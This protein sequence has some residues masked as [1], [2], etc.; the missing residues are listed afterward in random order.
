MNSITSSIGI[1]ILLFIV[2]IFEGLGL[3]FGR[4][5]SLC[6]ILIAPSILF[7]IDIYKRKKIQIP[8]HI[9]IGFIFFSI[10]A[11]I[12]TFT[13]VHIQTAF[14]HQLYYFTIFL[15]FL[16]TYN[17][18]ENIK[19]LLPQFIVTSTILVCLFTVFINFLLPETWSWLIPRNGYQFITNTH[20]S[21]YPIG[22]FILIPLI[23]CTS[24]LFKK[25]T[26]QTLL[27][28]FLLSIVLIGSFLRA[29]YVAYFLVL[30]FMI[31]QYSSTKK[32]F[33]V[34]Y[35]GVFSILLL[36]L[37]FILIT[38]FS[39]NI[40]VVSDS[41]KIFLSQIH[42]LENKT[43]LNARFEYWKQSYA[44]IMDKPV[45]G[46]GSFN[47][48]FAS[49]KFASSDAVAT[50]SSHNIF[51]D[52]FVENGLIAGILFIAIIMSLLKNGYQKLSEESGLDE[53]IFFIFFALLILF[54]FSHYHKMYF[55]F[56]FLFFL[57]G[58][59]YKEKESLRDK[60]YL[61]L[62][63]SSI[64]LV[65]GI[66]MILSTIFLIMNKSE[67]AIKIYPIF[68]RA[69]KQAIIDNM[70]IHNS[71]K[72]FQE[73]SYYS[74]LY[75]ESSS[76]LAFTGEFLKTYKYNKE[77]FYFYKKSLQYAP[78]DMSYV[79]NFYEL[80]KELKGEKIAKDSVEQY[81]LSHH[82][83]DNNPYNEMSWFYEWCDQNG[84]KYK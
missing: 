57:A 18:K 77:A 82:V 75:S 20:N 16:Y 78:Q 76:S 12:S 33:F 40:P 65:T 17:H 69:Y 73:L 83:F 56:T 47:F 41:Q 28:I 10:I 49:V 70:N 59:F 44:A 23:F 71:S 1:Y 30:F 21:H 7:A 31:F 60:H 38:K 55:L 29:G 46:F 66:I 2:L 79:M 61:I 36:V 9:S 45:L 58:L 11:A 25:N 6:S 34:K 35:F 53:S 32:T 50:G 15:L 62:Y 68:D 48:S 24:I 74:D 64:P 67:L 72:A 13:A 54:Q 4:F 22:A 51:L 80:L 8:Q 43:L 3:P 19:L 26:W 84:I 27:I 63:L 5:L 81:I 39:F 14:E 37:S 52:I 42:L